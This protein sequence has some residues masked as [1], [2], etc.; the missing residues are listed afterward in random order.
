MSDFIEEQAEIFAKENKL[1]H[2]HHKF[3][4]KDNDCERTVPEKI[5]FLLNFQ[6]HL[7]E[8]WRAKMGTN[9]KYPDQRE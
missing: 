8:A 7:S 3:G 6:T 2:Q 5:E 9:N 4:K 1:Y